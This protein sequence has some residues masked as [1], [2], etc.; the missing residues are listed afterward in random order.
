MEDCIRDL[1]LEDD[2]DD[3][4]E[5]PELGK[6]QQTSGYELCLVGTFVTDKSFNFVVMK[7][8][9]TSLWWLGR[10]VYIKDLGSKLILFRFKHLIDLR[11]VVDNGPRTFDNHL[12]LLHKL[13]PGEEPTEVPLHMADFWV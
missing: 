3:G 2:T 6:D 9:M 4:F 7:H 11:F 13:Q 5:F 12:L 1:V 10:G 8:R